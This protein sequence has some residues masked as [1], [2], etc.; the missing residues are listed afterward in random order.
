MVRTFDAQMIKA[1][2]KYLII[3]DPKLSSTQSN[4]DLQS[5]M[6]QFIVNHSLH[7]GIHK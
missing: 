4:F 1:N 7:V 6:F 3:K 5:F 2:D